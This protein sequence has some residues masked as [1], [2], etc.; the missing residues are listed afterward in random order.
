MAYSGGSARHPGA[1]LAALDWDPL[2]AMDDIKLR[3][4]VV[5]CGLMPGDDGSLNIAVAVQ[6]VVQ[7][8]LQARQWRFSR[9]V[10]VAPDFAFRDQGK[11]PP[12]RLR[13]V[14][15]RGFQRDL[16]VVQAVGV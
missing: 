7:H 13:S 11:G 6:H 12:H 5:K 8:L 4:P 14:M 1:S 2:L 9:N 10:V 16:G 3:F 15:E